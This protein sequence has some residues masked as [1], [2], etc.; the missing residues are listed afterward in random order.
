MSGVHSSCSWQQ[1]VCSLSRVP[2]A[3]SSRQSV[4][5]H[6][7]LTLTLFAP[8]ETSDIKLFLELAAVKRIGLASAMCSPKDRMALK[9]VSDHVRRHVV[10]TSGCGTGG[11]GLGGEKGEKEEEQGGRGFR[12]LLALEAAVLK[13]GLQ[14]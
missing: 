5:R 7:R 14:P 12:R 3:M 6:H 4:S 1:P 11:G 9:D 2:S 13:L 8:R 10:S